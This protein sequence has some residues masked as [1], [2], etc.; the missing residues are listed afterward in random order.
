MQAAIYVRPNGAWGGA[1]QRY[2]RAHLTWG[3]AARVGLATIG[4]VAVP[5]DLRNQVL[6]PDP[7][8]PWIAIEPVALVT[9]LRCT[10]GS[11]T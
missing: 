1:F 11:M 4:I 5:L 2:L 10:L 8:W 7:N 6:S 3:N 9:Y